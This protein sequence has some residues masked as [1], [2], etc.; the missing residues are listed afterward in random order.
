MVRPVTVQNNARVDVQA[1]PLGLEVTM[2]TVIGEPPLEAGAVQ[3]T[4]EEAFAAAVA[5]TAV[6]TPGTPRGIA[7]SDARD[8]TDEPDAFVAVTVN[9]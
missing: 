2:Y 4:T 6:G 7:P 5:D 9:V 8:A 1:S 3:D